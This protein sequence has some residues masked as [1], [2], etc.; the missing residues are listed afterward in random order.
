M[1]GSGRVIIP[2]DVREKAGLKAGTPLQVVYRDGRI[3][4]EPLPRAVRIVR[5]GRL[6]IAVAEDAAEPL[7]NEQVRETLDDLRLGRG[8]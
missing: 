8:D 6:S 2:S 3:E 1:D 4:I 7:T 5:R